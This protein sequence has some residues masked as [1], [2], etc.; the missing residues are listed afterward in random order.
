MKAK[1]MI[2]I[3]RDKQQTSLDN[4]ERNLAIQAQTRD[5]VTA[6][7]EFNEVGGLDDFDVADEVRPAHWP[8]HVEPNPNPGKEYSRVQAESF[9]CRG[10]FPGHAGGIGK[11]CLHPTLPMIATASDDKTWKMWYVIFYHFTDQKFCF[12]ISQI[13][14]ARH[15]M[16]SITYS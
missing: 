1:M 6:A 10:T 4:I 3:D 5:A 9:T 16:S 15:P 8:P 11:V 2:E 13:M 14:R 7:Q 12:S